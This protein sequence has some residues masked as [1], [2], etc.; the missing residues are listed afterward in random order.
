VFECDPFGA[1]PAVARPALGQ[2]RH[3]AVAVDPHGALYLTEDEPD[4]CFYRFVPRNRDSNGVPD[5]DAGTLQVAAVDNAGNVHWLDVPQ[6]CPNAAQ[7]PTRKQLA[8]ATHFNGGEGIWF[9]NGKV[10]FSTKGDDRV[11]LL[12][13]QRNH[14]SLLYDAATAQNRILTGVDNLAGTARG[15]LLVAED[16]GDMQ[17]VVIDAQRHI[18]PLLQVVG[19]QAS[20]I[21]GPAF[22]PDGSRLYFSSQR[23]SLSAGNAAGAGLTYEIS[24]PFRD[25]F[26]APAAMRG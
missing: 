10:Y 17:I 16:G 24:G 14:L 26:G 15:D 11:W 23:G 2:F 8:R 3:E 13:V 6:P 19:Q 7:P 5:L 1:R 9:D 4:G 25:I 21:T 12:D 20:E 22:S 18:A